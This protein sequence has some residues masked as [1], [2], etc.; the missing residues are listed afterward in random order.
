MPGKIA[1]NATT[2]YEI[3]KGKIAYNATTV[4]EIKKG[5]FAYNGTTVYPINFEEPTLKEILDYASFVGISGVNSSTAGHASVNLSGRVGTY[6]AFSIWSSVCGVYKIVSTG[7]SVSATYLGGNRTA[8]GGGLYINGTTIYCAKGDTNPTSALSANG[9]TLAVISANS[10]TAAQAETAIR[11]YISQYSM[12]SSGR[13]STSLA[14]VSLSRTY[15]A[16]KIVIAATG[17]RIA[18]LQMS[19]DNVKTI[20]SSKDAGSH[21][22]VYQPSAGSDLY[23]SVSGSSSETFYGGSLIAWG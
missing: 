2:V 13:S 12:S 17:S 14:A 4:Y 9:L 3:K 1:Y 5:K 23:L 10:A 8:A 11:D 19:S 18:F 22:L 16:G 21:G 7:T 6:F 15:S 20:L